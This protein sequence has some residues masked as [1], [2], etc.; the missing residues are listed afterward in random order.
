MNYSSMQRS[1]HQPMQSSQEHILEIVQRAVQRSKAPG[2]VACVGQGNERIF[3]GAA[4]QRA[5]APQHETA[6]VDTLYDLASLTK[7]VAT[8]TAVLL[9]RN[10][11]VLD[12]DQSVSAFIPLAHLDRF[13]LRHLITHASGIRAWDAFYTRLSGQ[14]PYIEAIA[15]CAA[16]A[17]PG[18]QR[19]YSDLG[20]ILLTRVVEQAAQENFETFCKTH[21]FDPLGMKDTCFKPTDALRQRCAPTENN[22]AR[23]GII[24]GEVH[25]DNAF[26][27]GGVSGHAGLFSTAEDLE[28]F[29]RAFMAGRILPIETLDEITR[30]GQLPY[31]PWQGL[32]WWLDPCASG[33]NGFL[34][35]RT[36]LGHT[37]WTGTSIW[38][39]RAN[40]VYAILL[41]NTCH[42]NQ[43]N[44]DN[45][46]LRRSFYTPLS[47]L[48]YKDTTN[49]QSGLDRLVRD[50][51]APLHEK[52]FALLSN[53]AAVDQTGRPILDV[54]ALDKSLTLRYIYSPEHGF[55]GSAEAGEKVSSKEGAVPIISLYGDRKEPSPS[56]LAGIDLFVVD[57]PDIGARYYT[58][59][60][61]MKSCMEA[62]A[63][64]KVP[65]LVL[66]RPNPVGG[67]VLEGPLP[68]QYKSSVCC[69]P[70]PIRH[71][72]TLAELALYFKD[73]FFANT[74][75][76]L[77]F[78]LA[79]NW[80]R[81]L[82][83]DQCNLPWVNPSPNIPNSEA[84]L[85]YVGTALFEGLNVNEGRGTE[86]PFL[87]CGAPWMNPIEILKR[88]DAAEHPGIALTGTIYMPKSIPGKATNP[89]YRDQ[90]CQGILFN[91]T[92]RQQAR[93]FKA[94]LAV[95]IAL[96]QC[97][98]ELKWENFFDTLAG[99]PWLREQ[100]LAGRS[101]TAITDEI[102][103]DL[104]NFDAKRPKLYAPLNTRLEL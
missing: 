76:K 46:E 15:A 63:K 99:G 65:V 26:A 57:L 78:S 50:K 20:F 4:G 31:Y 12:L 5:L 98:P 60:A 64:A 103:K 74:N 9:L 96:H 49:A 70:I 14:L 69:A 7:V 2:A 6:T 52:R 56:E 23:G 100:I 59:M 54:L 44:R 92:D 24:R 47:A 37:G 82:D 40:Q 94:T 45:G 34:T 25:D 101:A 73:T 27:L 19:T 41:S 53:T 13:T 33:P 55:T 75:L 104:V 93:P 66:D 91:I 29:C 35:A 77:N 72:M 84:A 68:A 86:T 48:F 58:Y 30:I 85:M 89:K 8:T 28:K 3:L 32:G 1:Y 17:Q 18:V 42:P 51:F 81:E 95:I 102:Q 38:M 10:A 61:T 16:D 62:C 22:K 36:A 97:H 79:D 88:I 43:K 39:D 71:G 87:V 21:I 67:A 80:W 90:L 11:G 83:F